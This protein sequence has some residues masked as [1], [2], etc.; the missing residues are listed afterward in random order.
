[1]SGI[2]N[3]QLNKLEKESGAS[4]RVFIRRHIN[5][6]TNYKLPLSF[7]YNN[8]Y[9]YVSVLCFHTGNTQCTRY[10]THDRTLVKL[11]ELRK[12]KI[13]VE[14]DLI[15]IERTLNISLHTE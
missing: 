6:L 7:V 5:L 14:S 1:M 15:L 10:T 11:N 8:A 12:K 3:G 2:N 4:L 9:I 13:Q